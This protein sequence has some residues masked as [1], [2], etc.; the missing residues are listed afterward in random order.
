M[1]HNV[2]LLEFSGELVESFD[3]QFVRAAIIQLQH[4]HGDAPYMVSVDG[5]D[6]G[7]LYAA[8]DNWDNH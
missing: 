6:L 4:E 7:P 8:L 1:L 2:K 3:T 5:A